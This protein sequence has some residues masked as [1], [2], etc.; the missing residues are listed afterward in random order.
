MTTITQAIAAIRARADAATA[1]KWIVRDGI[2]SPF[3][4]FP[5]GHDSSVL[6]DTDGAF[7]A[8]ARQDVPMLL[9]ALERAL[10]HINENGT[11]RGILTT[12]QEIASILSREGK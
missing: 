10:V 6:N 4:Q 1:G 3:V 12:K 8:S 5:N 11:E 2:R 9:D 7:I